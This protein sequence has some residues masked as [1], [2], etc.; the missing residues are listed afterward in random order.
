M[1]YTHAIIT[2]LPQQIKFESKKTAGKVD[3]EQAKKQQEDLT[4]TLREVRQ[5]KIQLRYT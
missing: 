2:R 3:L 1:R 5:R 4:E